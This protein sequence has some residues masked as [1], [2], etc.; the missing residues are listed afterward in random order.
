[1]PAD[2]AACTAGTREAGDHGDALLGIQSGRLGQSLK[3]EGLERV[4][5]QDRGRLVEGAM[6][7][8]A[9]APQIV[10][11]HRREVVVDQGVGMDE[12]D[13]TGGAVEQRGIHAECLACGIGQERADALA[14]AEDRVSHGLVQ[15]NRLHACRGQKGVERGLD[16]GA[17]ARAEVVQSGVSHW[18]RRAL[19]RNRIRT[20][21]RHRVECR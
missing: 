10:V 4:A 3:G 7:G 21:V 15:P 9:P 2:H 19:D 14:A 13:G 6:T 17:T 12:F 11:V 5:G 8:R 18:I 1:M 20:G 16:A